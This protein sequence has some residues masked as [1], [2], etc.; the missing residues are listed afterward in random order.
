[1]DSGSGEAVR[2]PHTAS[3]PPSPGPGS[4]EPYTRPFKHAVPP[5]MGA[6]AG[7][8]SGRDPWKKPG[9][10]GLDGEHFPDTPFY[11]PAARP[12]KLRRRTGGQPNRTWSSRYLS[13]VVP[14]GPP[15]PRNFGHVTPLT[16]A[17]SV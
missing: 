3:D 14:P 11:R 17:K 5:G 2:V 16:G 10:H 7:T 6:N 1:M 9:C 13:H 4:G 15:A 8:H 12:D